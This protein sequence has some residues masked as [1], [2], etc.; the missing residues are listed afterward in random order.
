MV[1]P[2][3]TATSRRRAPSTWCCVSGKACRF[4]SRPSLARR[5]VFGQV[6][7]SPTSFKL[8]EPV[9][10]SHDKSSPRTTSL[11]P[12]SAWAQTHDSGIT[13]DAHGEANLHVT[14]EQQLAAMQTTC[15]SKSLN[16][17][18]TSRATVTSPSYPSLPHARLNPRHSSTLYDAHEPRLRLGCGKLGKHSGRLRQAQ[19]TRGEGQA[20]R[21]EQSNPSTRRFPRQ[22]I[23][24]RL[25]CTLMN[26]DVRRD[27]PAAKHCN[28]FYFP[29]C[30]S[31]CDY[32]RERRATVTRV[33]LS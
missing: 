16:A 7:A 24:T 1:V 9:S 11:A 19:T 27:V 3:L 29:L 26:G 15:L 6:A 17:G 14:R 2:L 20:S 8:E 4:S 28:S 23:M 22:G 25:Q 18:L 5:P 30:P 33:R 13:T 31:P 32:K 12:T 10:A 21:K